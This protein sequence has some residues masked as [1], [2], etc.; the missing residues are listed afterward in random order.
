MKLLNYMLFFYATLFLSG[1]VSTMED[2][3]AAKGTG[4]YRIYDNSKEEVWP[5]V[6]EAIES[7]ELI[8]VEENKVSG[9]I[10]AR[11][12]FTAFS[13]GENVAIFVE[14]QDE[15]KCR[16]EVISKK[17]VSTTI[18]APDWSESIFKNIDAKL[19]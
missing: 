1:C 2:S 9:S 10:L 17:V 12:G 5:V 7:S 6:I 3:I 4:Q 18:F 16:V 11:R 8:L 13:Y 14:D 19:K 15:K